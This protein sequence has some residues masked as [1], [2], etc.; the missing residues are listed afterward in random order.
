MKAKD[1]DIIGI[2]PIYFVFGS[3]YISNLLTQKINPCNF[4][5]E[6]CGPAKLSHSKGMFALFYDSEKTKNYHGIFKNEVS[7]EVSLSSIPKGEQ[8]EAYLFFNQDAYSVYCKKYKEYWKWVEE[9]NADRYE[10]NQK[11]GKNYDSKNM[12][13]TIRL[14]QSAVQILKTG[15]LDIWV[16]N[17][18]EL[19]NIKAGNQ[20]YDELLEYADELI[21]NL[22]VSF[23]S[24]IL[25]ELPDKMKAES[26][27]I[28]IKNSII[29]FKFLKNYFKPKWK[30]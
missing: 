5:P 9:W 24:S 19:L 3:V 6:H 7:N 14:L 25:Q 28:N 10:T 29:Q 22:N 8:L 13:H 12:M 18:N 16:K 20:D 15:T 21:L 27:L 11:H 2:Y 4:N 23:K 26:T 1:Y 17:C 30:A